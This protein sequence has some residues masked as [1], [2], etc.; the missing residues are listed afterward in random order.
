[1]DDY[2]DAVDVGGAFTDIVLYNLAINQQTVHKTPST[3]E[4]PSRGFL[5]G[6]REVPEANSVEPAQVKHVFHETTIT[7]IG[8]GGGSIT[9]VTP[10]GSVNVA[11]PA[12]ARRPARCVTTIYGRR[13][14][15]CASTRPAAAGGLSYGA[16]GGPGAG[17]RFGRLR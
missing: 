9:S 13:A 7:T 11:P 12:P 8:C 17:R 3:T 2:S 14:T 6:L 15:W 16:R 1:M 10:Y 4:D 5:T